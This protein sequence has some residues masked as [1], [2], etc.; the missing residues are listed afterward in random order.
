MRIAA[1]LLGVGGA[2]LWGVSRLPWLTVNVFDDKSG[3]STHELVG[4]VWSTE[5][6]ALALVLLAAMVAGLVLRR[7]ARRIIGIVGAAAAIAASWQPLALLAGEPDLARAKNILTSGAATER[8]QSPVLIASWADVSG[9]EVHT[10][11]PA[12]AFCAC[13]VALFGGVLLAMRP[14][15]DTVRSRAYER[16][17]SR[18]ETLAQDM[19]EAPDSGRVLWD[20]LDADIDPTDP[21]GPAADSKKPS[22]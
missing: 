16:A 17:S 5:L 10:L 2:A 21:D 11:G 9:A 18:Q 3:E 19:A 12:L 8:A 15:A 14:G 6:T 22:V 1:V 20:A 13:A 4:A 7:T